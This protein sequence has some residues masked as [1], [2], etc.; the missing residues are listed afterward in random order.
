MVRVPVLQFARFALWIE[1]KMENAEGDPN[2]ISTMKR[3]FTMKRR[4]FIFDCF[5]DSFG[6]SKC[7]SV[8]MKSDHLWIQM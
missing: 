3:R 7:G 4:T 1:R 2:F 6:T 8:K 5:E